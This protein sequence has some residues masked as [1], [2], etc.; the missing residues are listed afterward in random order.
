ME[1]GVDIVAQLVKRHMN[2][3]AEG[4]LLNLDSISLKNC[5][6]VSKTWYLVVRNGNLW[7]QFY[8]S[9]S[10]ENPLL[11]TLLQ[12]RELET[13]HQTDSDEF[14]FK[15]LFSAQQNLNKNWNCGKY[16]TTKTTLGEVSVSIF[17][18]DTKRF[19]FV[20]RSSPAVPSSI[21]VWNRWTLHPEH[22]LVG[23]QEWVTDLQICGDLIFCS[24]YDGTV[25]VWDLDTKEVVQQFQDQEVLDWVVI[26]AAHGLLVT[27]TSIA[28]GPDA[29]DRDTTITIR[30]IHSP[31]QMVVERQEDIPCMKVC[32][33]QSDSNYF[34]VF[35][36]STDEIKLQLRSADFHCLR[37][38]CDV[39]PPDVSFAYHSDRLVTGSSDG[40]IKIWDIESQTCEYTWT[41][42]E[43][44]DELRINSRHIITRNSNGKLTVWNLPGTTD[45]K[46]EEMA[47]GLFQIKGE[48]VGIMDPSFAFDELQILAVSVKDVSR[49]VSLSTLIVRDFMDQ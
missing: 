22:T 25:L 31:T 20:L 45:C 4:I 5:E 48:D 29:N 38:I 32:R 46:D 33:L 27:C 2:S 44:I 12:R 30:R 7:K 19:L 37:Q 3:I 36:T 10:K 6:A 26:H 49:T 14:L 15:R 11:Q 35:L 34:V 39:I 13:T 21:M 40:L 17:V 1:A 18:M 47:K 8:S 24:Y 16:F 23:H 41:T 28:S 43:K 42:Q 9:V